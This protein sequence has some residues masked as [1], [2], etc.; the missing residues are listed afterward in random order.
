MTGNAACNFPELYCKQER[1]I[2]GKVT[3]HTKPPNKQGKTINKKPQTNKNKKCFWR[4]GKKMK[5]LI[6]QESKLNDTDKMKEATVWNL[7]LKVSKYL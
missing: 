5:T 4:E 6:N 2:S 3:F 7:L 1:L